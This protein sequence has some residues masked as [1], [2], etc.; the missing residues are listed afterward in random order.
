M[1]ERPAPDRFTRLLLL[2]AAAAAL[3][4]TAACALIYRNNYND[5]V[6]AERLEAQ[7]LL[8]AMAADTGRLLDYAD[9]NLRAARLTYAGQDRG[10]DWRG[11]IDGLAAPGAHGV[12]TELSIL[13]ADGRMVYRAGWSARALAGYGDFRAADH[14]QQ[15]SA[16]RGDSLFIGATRPGLL[17]GAL[18]FRV[19]RP[20]LRNGVFAGEVVLN[21]QPQPLVDFLGASGLGAHGSLAVLTADGKLLARAPA[22]PAS[23]YGH[24]LPGLAAA[25]V[26]L[27]RPGVSELR[28]VADPVDPTRR[29]VDLFWTR[30][31]SYPAAVLVA[32]SR[33]DIAAAMV[34]SRRSLLALGAMFIAADLLVCLL[35]LRMRG[36]T[37]RLAQLLGE[38]RAAQTELR[39]AATAFEAREAMLIAD[40]RGRVVRVNKA[41]TEST[42][43][44]PEEVIGQTPALLKS[45]RHDADFYAGMWRQLTATGAWQGEIWDKRKNGEVFPKWLTIS[46]VKDAEGRVTHYVG[47][48]FD[49]T[50]RKLAEARIEELAFYDQL[51]GLPNRTLLLDRLGQALAETERSRRW[52][53]LLFIDLDRFKVLNDTLGHG[54]GDLLLKQ[55]A[56]RLQECVRASDT[57]ARL[58]GDEFV[59]L[60]KDLDPDRA[61]AAALAEVVAEKIVAA[62]NQPY[63]LHAH[64]HHSTPSIGVAL[65]CDSG[66]SRDEVLKQADIA[67][68]QAKAAG[69]NAVRFFDPEMQAGV[70]ARVALEH[71]LRGAL[72]MGEFVLHYQPLVDA[73]GH[74]FGAE[75]LVRWRHPTRGMV[76]PDLF[77]PLAEETGLI[78]ELGRWV[79]DA[80]CTRLA[81]WARLPGLDAL[82][83]AVNVSA[84]QLRH[85]DFVADVA[86]A[87]RRSGAR[88]ERLKLELTESLLLTEID[89]TIAKMAELRALG[90]TFNLDDF[91]T[92][93]SS[94]SY[95]QRLPLETLKID[96]SFVAQMT[97]DANAAAIA[98][99]VVALARA[100][101]LEV[102]AEGVETEA[103]HQA[104]AALGCLRY[105]GYLFGRPLSA[106]DFEVRL[107][108]VEV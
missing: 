58:G 42:G 80:A 76:S 8:A 70:N 75:A 12:G 92:G 18:E 54:Y 34:E 99:T 16:A 69:R 86:D 15:L 90:V 63:R 47:T 97:A 89:D 95:L 38:N 41:F 60:L 57:A 68:Y 20:L 98:R 102:L 61:E 53:A 83:V 35:V 14:F 29:R 103:Q 9:T 81:A 45:G 39:I 49:I 101:S 77:I 4:F 13:G 40:A 72:R 17:T 24:V 88:P 93:Y 44:A 28:D 65:F 82:T 51:T 100:L 31:G 56:L 33:A 106:G 78:L 62:L 36:Q 5:R 59:V 22:A 84:R 21:L 7:R 43:Y 30:V 6:A 108:A 67:M 94:L 85:K 19:A 79:L 3:L 104:L 48:H 46:A 91:G 26:D 27:S 87:L 37:R 66:E 10:A 11:R 107:G 105:Q 74:C 50:E 71:D 2:S 96:R 64:E 1:I 32:V 23:A 73:A 25:G 55:V 52:G